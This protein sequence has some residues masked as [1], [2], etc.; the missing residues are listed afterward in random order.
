MGYLSGFSSCRQEPLILLLWRSWWLHPMIGRRLGFGGI[1]VVG[2]L[3]SLLASWPS[4]A[5]RPSGRAFHPGQG[6]RGRGRAR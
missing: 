2:L 5:E 3:L 6:G 1:S 4:V